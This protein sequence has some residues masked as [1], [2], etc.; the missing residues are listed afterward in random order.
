M[1]EELEKTMAENIHKLND[2]LAILKRLEESRRI[3]RELAAHIAELEAEENR[4]AR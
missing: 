2:N 1:Y 3:K 4:N